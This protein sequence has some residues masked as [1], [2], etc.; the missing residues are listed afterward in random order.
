MKKH[1]SILI[2]FVLLC[3]MWSCKTNPSHKSPKK[4]ADSGADL[5]KY[6]STSLLI[7]ASRAKIIGNVAEAIDLYKTIIKNDP[8]N[9]VASYELANLYY[10]QKS[11]PEALV[12]AKKAVEYN[13]AQ[14]WYSYLLAMV[15]N[16]TGNFSEST[17]LY[18]KLAEKNPF[19]T[20]YLYEW[21][22]AYLYESKYNEA[23]KVYDKIEKITGIDEQ[24]ILQKQKLYL[25]LNKVD[26][27]AEE[28]TKLCLQYPTEVRYVLMIADMYA[29][30]EM[31]DKAFE[32]Y[33]KALAIDSLNP[34]IHLSLSDFYK[35]KGDTN[36]F[37]EE[38]R[39][40]FSS[41]KLDIDTK[42]KVLVSYYTV[43]ETQTNLRSQAYELLDTLVRVHP[44]DP[45]GF[46]ML[47]DFLLRDKKDDEARKVFR[48]VISLDSSKYIVW[49]QL[50]YLDA[51][52]LDDTA[53][54]EESKKTMDLF[55]EQAMPYLFYGSSILRKG[56]Y[57]EAASVLK[58]GVYYVA[59]N[60][61][62]QS[63]F[64]TY[65]GDAYYQLKKNSESDKAYD[66]ALSYVADNPYVLNNYSYYLS[67]RNEKLDKAEDMA[68]KANDLV[69]NNA[70]YL[71]TYAW[72]LYKE[73][74]STEAKAI[75]EKALQAGGDK[76]AVIVEHYGD[77]LFVSGEKEKAFV[78]WNIAKT[79]GKASDLLDK[80]INERNLF[81]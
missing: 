68:K 39:Y 71:D 16:K 32:Y 65:L 28:M 18:Q 46:S 49:E 4:S 8:K 41:P 43:S 33:K 36:K 2:C 55:P 9:S 14:D 80:K 12:Y 13:P 21:A 17:K 62:L 69:K 74:K 20:Q 64:Y 78:Q 3:G 38:I 6:K 44:N 42:I 15:Y 73:K 1:L 47:G 35:K 29:I 30:N 75:I 11:Y 57:E 5:F 25:Q 7:D 45:K 81:E 48:K 50:L 66:K 24:I 22:Y 59:D 76:N 72:V 56:N 31:P 37:L 27:A 63:Q 61:E 19:Q 79:L 10:S 54:L 67:L 60:K 77:I 51:S 52:L 34:Y 23:I 70:S 53:L 40:C 58:K 26:K